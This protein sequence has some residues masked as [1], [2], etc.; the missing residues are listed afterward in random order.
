MAPKLPS[1]PLV[2]I[3]G[4][5]DLAVRQRANEIF[6]AWSEELGG[7]DHEI[8][9]GQVSNTS[10]ALSCLGKV[11]EALQT[12]PFFGGGKAVWLKSVSFLGDD[13]TASSAAVTDSVSSLA[14]E[15][16]AFDFTNVRF[17]V[18]AGKVDKRKVFFKT[19]KA[20]GTIESFEGL[21]INDR[22]WE[23]KASDMAAQMFRERE[24]QISYEAL[25]LFVNYV[26]PDARALH[27]EAEK[28]SLYV[29]DAPEI[30]AQHV[31]EITTRNKHARAFALGEALGERDLKGLLNILDEEIWEMKTDPKKTEIGLLYGLIS[32]VRVMLGV[33]EAMHQ[34]LL[35]EERNFN[36]F[37]GALAAIPA[38]AMPEVARANPL[39]ANPFVVFKASQQCRNYTSKELVKGMELLLE[40]NRR[41]VQTQTDSA[42]LLQQALT[43][44]VARKKK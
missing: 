20:S 42:M 13:R 9:D 14:K 33:K 40:C 35:R 32:K 39:A 5:D 12:L 44:L 18:S 25:A 19:F 27:S 30:T 37:K 34:G 11:R 1:T 3:C 21:S 23:T 17:I 10:E 8:I 22:D 6:K 28:L 4:E 29:A 15:L 7:M 24:K 43:T 38:G 2:L 16:K 26:G 36:G 41:L 31:N